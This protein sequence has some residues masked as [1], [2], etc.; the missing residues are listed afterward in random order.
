MLELLSDTSSWGAERPRGL[1]LEASAEPPQRQLVHGGTAP[2]LAGEGALPGEGPPEPPRTRETPLL[3][4][5]WPTPESSACE[6][7]TGAEAASLLS[8]D[9]ASEVSMPSPLSE[10]SSWAAGGAASLLLSTSFSSMPSEPGLPKRDLREERP[11]RRQ[12]AARGHAAGTTGPAPAA[13]AQLGAALAPPPDAEAATYPCSHVRG[14]AAAGAQAGQS[15]AAEPGRS[16]AAQERDKAKDEPC[17]AA[18]PGHG[19]E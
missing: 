17:G 2:H 1:S 9:M 16:H 6:R 15:G 13:D 8:A 7:M 14:L 18:A 3:S 10:G 19:G 12:T 5:L 4:E 11:P